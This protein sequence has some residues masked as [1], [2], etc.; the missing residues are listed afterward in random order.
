MPAAILF[1]PFVAVTVL[2]TVAFASHRRKPHYPSGPKGRFLVGNLFDIPAQKPWKVYREWGKL[3]GDYIHMDFFGQHMLVVNSWKVAD[4]LFEKRS[5]IYSDRPFIAMA[6]LTGW[7]M[8]A[9]AKGY[10]QEWRLHRKLYQQGFR[11][12]VVP[13]YQPILSSKSSQFMLNLRQSPK[14]FAE[15]IRTY[16]AA[17]ILAT[18]YGYDIAPTNDRFVAIAEETMKTS[19]VIGQ[20]SAVVVN[21]LPFLRHLPLAIPIFPFQRIARRVR[22]MLNEMRTEPYEFVKRNMAVGEGKISLVAKL[23]E[24]HANKSEDENHVEMIK[25]VAATSYAGGADTSASVLSTFF[26]AMA[27][28]PKIQKQAQN[29]LEIVSGKG[30]LP[31]Y[32]DRSDFPYMEA[33]LR[34][35]LRWAPVFPLGVP[36]RAFSDDTIDGYF[37]PK[38]TLVIAN[39]WAMTRDENLYP[40]PESFVPERYLM[41]DGGCNDDQLMLAFGFGRRICPGRHFALST[42]WTAMVS[43]LSE[44]EIGPAEDETG[45]PITK[46]ADVNYSPGIMSHP[47]PYRCTIKP[48][49]Q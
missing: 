45:R 13:E 27:L 40:E 22:G 4:E 43:I 1:W 18:V 42:L 35:T 33:I 7:V 49:K 24:D 11:S 31:T 3:Y 2:V 6:V 44:F 8:N 41:E 36:H 26:L 19:A 38:G 17:T 30:S 47:E 32:V 10:G 39:A 12:T 28:H 21:F 23:L 15:H 46:L 16:A 5:R 14:L 48:R 20:P 25:D 34:E 9:G 37:I 29:E